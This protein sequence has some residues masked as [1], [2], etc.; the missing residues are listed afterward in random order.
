[1]DDETKK[2]VQDMLDGNI[3]GE[4]LIRIIDDVANTIATIGGHFVGALAV[5]NQI[6]T[7]ATGALTSQLGLIKMIDFRLAKQLEKQE[8]I[9]EV[10]EHA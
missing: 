4:M 10:S 7:V 3:S 9:T 6:C 2:L 5:N 1:M 8:T